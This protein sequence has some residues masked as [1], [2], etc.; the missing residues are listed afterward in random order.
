[1]S[2]VGRAQVR[3]LAIGAL[4]LLI[5]EHWIDRAEARALWVASTGRPAA[6]VFVGHDGL[7]IARSV[8]RYTGVVTALGA[9]GAD[10]HI[11]SFTAAPLGPGSTPPQANALRGW[12]LTI[13]AGNR[14][15][16]VFEVSGNTDAEL[17]VTTLD[18]PLDG[19]GVSDVFV[20]E[21]IP[22]KRPAPAA[23]GSL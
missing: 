22:M 9:P 15:S 6:L 13:L 19:L 17:T 10:G 23:A 21:D 2:S 12:R 3:W 16:S 18:G 20:V 7:D 5:G 14:F 1:M 8:R 11:H 4:T